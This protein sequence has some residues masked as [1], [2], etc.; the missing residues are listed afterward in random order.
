MPGTSVLPRRRSRLIRSLVPLVALV[1]VT[2]GC[3]F[4]TLWGWGANTDWQIGAG[5]A[6]FTPSV[7]EQ[8]Q[9]GGMT[10]KTTSAGLFHSC[11]IQ[12]D[13]TL[14]CWGRNRGGERGDGGT[15]A[16]SSYG[17]R[18]IKVGSST[19]KAV[20]ASTSAH[21]CGIQTN[22]TLWCW[23]GN[24]Q[25]PLGDGTTTSRTTPVP[26]GT[27]TWKAVSAGGSHTCAIRSDD[28]L[29]C[30][31]SNSHG[32]LGDGT[33]TNRTTPGQVGSGTWK[34]ISATTSATTC[35][36]QSDDTLWCWGYNGNGQVGDGTTTSRTSPVPIGT[37]TWRTVSAG[38][39][40]G[41]PLGNHTCAI[42]T[43]STLW[44]W[45]Q[46]ASW[47]LLGNGS[48]T[49]QL[50]PAQVGSSSWTSISLGGMHRCGIQT[51][52]TLWCW[53]RNF[54]GQVGDGKAQARTTAGPKQI[55]DA[56]WKDVSGGG[57]HTCAISQL[58]S[59]MWCWG[60][61]ADG[62][63]GYAAHPEQTTPR[64]VQSAQ[65]DWKAASAGYE[66]SCAIDLDDELRCWGRNDKG[67][68]GDRTTA[69]K[70]APTEV[71][72]GSEWTS[73]SAGF[74]HTCGIRKVGTLWCWGRNDTY[75]AVGDGTFTDRTFPV[76]VGGTETWTSVDTSSGSLG[77][78]T[79]AIRADDTLWC[80]GR[81]DVGQLGDGST[82]T[83]S[84][85]VQVG[86]ESWQ[87][88]TVGDHHTCAIRTDQTMW[89]WGWNGYG[90]LGDGTLATRTEPIQVDATSWTSVAA[91][92]AHTCATRTGGALFC[93]GYNSNGQLGDGT[94][95]DRSEPGTA[96]SDAAWTSVSSGVFHTCG[97]Q[98]DGSLWCWG[99][100]DK[101]QLGF[102]TT[103]EEPAN[104]AP[105]R[106]G[107]LSTWT[108]VSAGGAHTLATMVD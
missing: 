35:G 30:W 57:Y 70:V 27:S 14:W 6:T 94:T 97:L 91:G 62:Q 10:W 84:V 45:G 80:W 72:L 33:L 49:P 95:T 63:L 2:S 75:G 7:P 50:T 42:R 79:C 5:P 15:F 105:Q 58:D 101:G 52:D 47:D 69:T 34:T 17:S 4:S 99:R 24:G 92:A 48:T 65:G 96:I 81:N 29:W 11:G 60:E 87:S 73:V 61:N 89:C 76:N 18:P 20:S 23:G 107:T 12:R 71:Y 53:G 98:N 8:T 46:T 25:G 66:H 16:Q 21:T 103:T 86:I 13:D 90:Q 55:G 3:T 32:Q 40:G 93:W 108:S 88:V 19:W 43:D 74:Q 59:T 64:R 68:V 85:P 41:P 38:G 82:E 51:D 83:R 77:H 54:E 36:I 9:V 44:C 28:T 100:N 22:D 31:G 104:R 56:R 102:G 67:Q 106:A 37:D 39:H 78:H 26:V 1:L